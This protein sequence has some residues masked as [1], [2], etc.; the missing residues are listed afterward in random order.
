MYIV[1]FAIYKLESAASYINL[2][3]GD[4]NPCLPIIVEKKIYSGGILSLYL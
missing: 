3:G 2:V 4:V 1:Y